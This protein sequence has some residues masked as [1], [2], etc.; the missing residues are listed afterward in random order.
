[1][2][3]AGSYDATR[4]LQVGVKMGLFDCIG[5]KRLSVV[6]VAKRLKAS[7]HGMEILLNALVGLDL[8]KKRNGCY[9]LNQ[10]SR[11]HLLSS[12]P[13]SFVDMIT[14]AAGN[15]E[16]FA[17]LEKAVRRGKPMRIP[18]MF[19][20]ESKMLNHFIRGMHNL[21]VVRGDAKILAKK[22]SLKSYRFLLDIGGGPGTYSIAFCRANPRLNAAVYD[23]PATCRI[24]QKMLAENDNTGRVAI[25]HGDFNKDPLP[26]GFD[27]ALLSNIIHSETVQDN[28]RLIKKIYRSLNPGGKILIKDHLLSNDLTQPRVGAVFALTMLLFTRG[29][30]YS[31]KEVKGWLKKAGFKKLR[32]ARMPKLMTTNVLVGEKLER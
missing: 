29:R 12:N 11:K 17:E 16:G 25:F 31:E 5:T 20:R 6:Q 7:R 1:M 13:D 2:Q 4:A 19:Q 26:E 30:C 9:Y 23:L 32:I 24:T 28:H 10:F 21:S 18:D 14:F 8:L 15:Y 22:L 3:L 27:V